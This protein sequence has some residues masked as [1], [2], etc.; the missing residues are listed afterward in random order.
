M[1]KQSDNDYINVNGEEQA[2]QVPDMH[3]GE[4]ASKMYTE[5]EMDKLLGMVSRKV[6]ERMEAQFVTKLEKQMSAM[7][8][9]FDNKLEELML[10]RE[11]AHGE[12]RRLQA[13][14]DDV[15]S[16]STGIC[17]AGTKSCMRRT[18]TVSAGLAKP[19]ARAERIDGYDRRCHEFVAA[20]VPH[21][22]F[23]SRSLESYTQVDLDAILTLMD[24]L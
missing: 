5:E 8:R 16:N 18:G 15:S 3:V 9:S 22:V 13:L 1:G 21:D 4:V 6:E 7:E 24:R 19:A 10:E 23:A 17:E 20:Q 12:N 2:G 11:R 14:V